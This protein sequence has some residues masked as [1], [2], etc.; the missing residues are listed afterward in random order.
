MAKGWSKPV[1]DISG[2][3]VGKWAVIR[4]LG[5]IH[6]G[7]TTTYYLCRCECG[8]ER[9]VNS[10]ALRRGKS[11]S[12]GCYQREVARNRWTIHGLNDHPLRSHYHAMKSRCY[13]TRNMGY[14]NYGGR[15]VKICQ[16]WLD[17]Y[18]AFVEWA[19][20]SG[21]A[22]G[23]TIDRIDVNGDYSPDNCRWI[24]RAEQS[25]NT[26]RN[27]FYTYQGQTKTL[28][29]WSRDLKIPYERLRGRLRKCGCTFEEAVKMEEAY[30]SH[31]D[32]LN[33]NIST[34]R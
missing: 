31:H 9:P 14:P 7:Q 23:L 24:T 21:W 26:R 16:E 32:L 28:T 20:N 8:V 27:K 2:Q 33:T 19:L 1:K 11:I 6:P 17:S 13:D 4:Y 10:S 30:V 3:K 29:Q 15:G 34:H 5:A 12:C 22:E 18:P 25:H